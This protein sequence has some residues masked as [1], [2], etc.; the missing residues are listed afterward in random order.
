MLHMTL[1]GVPQVKLNEQ[2]LAGF[3]SGKAKALLF[4][5]ATNEGS[6]SRDILAN[7]L[8][9]DM[10]E[11][12]AR[13]SLRSALHNLRSL[14][15]SHLIITRETVAFNRETPYW[16]DVEIVRAGL[17]THR[18][19]HTHQQIQETIALYRGEFLA[20]FHINDAPNFEEWM[21]REREHLRIQMI[22]EL[23]DLAE[24]YIHKGKSETG[25][26]VTRRLLDLEPWHE[27]AHRQQMIL[28]AQSGRRSAALLQYELCCQVLEDE[29]DV[30]PAQ[31][32]RSLYARLK[33]EEGELVHP[34]TYQT[35]IPNSHA[36]HRTSPA[37]SLNGT[38][39]ASGP[40][41]PS[42]P[43]Q[44]DRYTTLSRLEPPTT[45]KLFGVTELRAELKTA[46]LASDRPWLVALE[47]IGGI[48][49]TTL[50]NELAHQLV[51][52]DRFVDI[53]WIS[54]KQESFLP[55]LGLQS[56]D[57]PALDVATLTDT[58]LEQLDERPS[59]TLSSEEKQAALMRLLKQ[60]PHLVVVDNLETAVD[61]QALLPTLRRY[62]NPAKFL[63]TSR[64]SLQAHADVT[65]LSLQELSES[66]T[67]P[68]MRLSAAIRWL[69]TYIYWQAWQMLDDAAR[70]LI[71]ALPVVSHADFAAL[72]M[73]SDLQV[74][75][76]HHALQQLIALSLVQVRGD[77]ENR[78]YSLHR[79]TETFLMNEVLQWR[80]ST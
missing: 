74:D 5:I 31:E 8:W 51:D 57:Q 38:N 47:G 12:K 32:T 52:D 53:A 13:H 55:E 48:G 7:L 4:Y 10:P 27:R 36:D 45:Q 28:L 23:S 9:A 78:L 15:G 42:P 25:L 62:A 24:G 33:A 66:D 68:F 2:P 76:L 77:L 56:I 63:L 39:A 44:S 29:F 35:Y 73:I 70:T 6:A 67:L 11:Q 59:S 22:D 46:V 34:T 1:F 40:L 58:L 18:Q 37:G 3:I 41:D 21:I 71:L 69:Y 17:T 60:H 72:G 50:A 65:C 19:Q 49:K 54:A 64:F 20:G 26:L 61:Y 14:V 43:R 80:V 75:Q 16:L 79:L 30:E